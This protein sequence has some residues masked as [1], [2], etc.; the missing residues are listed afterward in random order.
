MV[1]EEG[2]GGPT[3]EGPERVVAAVVRLFRARYAAVHWRAAGSD[4]LACVVQWGESPAP[5]DDTLL[6]R[7]VAER[8]PVQ[9]PPEA[10]S[11]AIVLPLLAHGQAVGALLL[12]D[13]AGRTFTDDEIELLTLIA[14]QTA[15]ALDSGRLLDEVR[16]AQA[17]AVQ[18]QKLEALGRLAGGIAHEFNNLLTV[19]KGR[20]EQLLGRPALDA[21]VRKQVERIHE[22][23][24]R[25]VALTLQLMTYAG[26]VSPETKLID[27]NA[28]VGKVE[29]LLRRLVGEHIELA[30]EAAP[31]VGRVQADAAQLEQAITSLALHARDAMPQGGRLLIRTASATLDLREAGEA[32]VAPGAYVVLTVQDSG[33][34][35]D[36]EAQTRLFEPYF[37][38]PGPGSGEA[39]GLGL[40]AA[41]GAVRRLGGQIRVE[42]GAGRGTTLTLYLPRT[43]AAGRP[44]PRGPRRPRRSCW[45]RTSG[46][47]WSWP[48]RS[49]PRTATR[50]S[51]RAPAR[52][53]SPSPSVT[54]ARSICC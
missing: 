39:T 49:S 4:A 50:S 51:A 44:R 37:A 5:P 54:R 46:T 31:D 27:V 41:Y 12:A 6:A 21:V 29:S 22:T 17:R 11:A 34:G 24:D 38:G 36:A 23:A 8:R 2:K 14:D 40:A 42:S 3:G 53:A 52:R 25:A 18:S 28:L 16:D 1:V 30:I 35:L 26:E 13:R 9:A 20:T 47:C 43:V 45:P 48:R 15:V 32:G 33:A 7:A 10:P 19:I